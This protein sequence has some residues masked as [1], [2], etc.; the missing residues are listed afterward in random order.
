MKE[1]HNVGTPGIDFTN[2][3]KTE[4]PENS[5]TNQ[6][7][8]YYPT[9]PTVPRTLR[10]KHTPLETGII[11]STLNFFIASLDIT[12]Q[13][14]AE[15]YAENYGKDHADILTAMAPRDAL[16]AERDMARAMVIPGAPLEHLHS[17]TPTWTPPTTTTTSPTPPPT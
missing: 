11:L 10:I 16:V 9:L 1:E 8:E 7:K 15:Y 12:T 13:E 6:V 2:I 17:S 3:L 5:T 14:I 4:E